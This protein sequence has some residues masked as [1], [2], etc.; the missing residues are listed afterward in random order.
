MKNLRENFIEGIKI[1]TLKGFDKL[2]KNSKAF[3]EQ[4]SNNLSNLEES[5]KK[6][7]QMN[8]YMLQLKSPEKEEVLRTKQEKV[9]ESLKRDSLT[10]EQ[11][12][13]I[14]DTSITTKS[15]N[16]SLFSGFKTDFN[17]ENFRDFEKFLTFVIN[18]G[19]IRKKEILYI[20]HY[21]QERQYRDFFRIFF[22][23]KDIRGLFEQYPAF[24]TFFGLLELSNVYLRVLYNKKDWANI[25]NF[26][27]R[28]QGVR[29]G[30]KSDQTLLRMSD[31][32]R[33]HPCFRRK[34]FWIGI[35]D[36]LIQK[37]M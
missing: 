22:S 3:N 21:L 30:F 7:V 33:Y 28:I 8:R 16:L 32:L 9:A 4:F 31:K 13:E 5:I 6:E 37:A 34:K 25:G 17:K 29:C 19:S 15:M 2:I 1:K 10:S 14:L 24:N 35:L 27:L 12:L 11:V 36:W 18:G 26:V 23:K 20:R